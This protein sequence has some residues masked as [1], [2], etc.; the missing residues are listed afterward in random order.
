MRRVRA[1]LEDIVTLLDPIGAGRLGEGGG[2]ADVGP[3]QAFGV[4]VLGLDVEG[5]RYFDYHHTHADTFDKIDRKEI[6][7]CEA[8][9]CRQGLAVPRT[10]AGTGVA[11]RADGTRHVLP[12]RRRF[13]NGSA[14]C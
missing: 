4:P 9:F 7:S 1:Q 8:A 6:L 12:G 5:S 11:V 13:L 14:V 2:G 3:M 10:L